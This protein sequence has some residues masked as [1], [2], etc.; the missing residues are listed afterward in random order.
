MSQDSI[1]PV[2]NA[3]T[4]T[5]SFDATQPVRLSVINNDGE[6]NVKGTDGDTITVTATLV[7]AHGG[8]TGREPK[9]DF[10]VEEHDNAISIRPNWQVGNTVSDI[11]Q[12]VKTQLKE[13]FRSEDWDF[14]KMRFAGDATYD[15]EV[16][17]PRHLP[18]GSSVALKTTSGDVHV[19]GLRTTLSV[20]TASG[21]SRVER[22]EGKTSSHSASGD[23]TLRQ[24]SGSVEANTASGDVS[25]EDGDAWTALRS[26]SG[27]ISVRNVTLKNARITTVSGNV[28]VD[29]T[30]NN[31]A[32][33]SFDSVSGDMR[34]TT[35]V[36]SSGAT[37]TYRSMSGDAHMEGDWTKGGGKRSWTI[38]GAE[39]GPKIS[40]KTVSG[41]LRAHGTIS[42]DLETRTETMPKEVEE[43][44]EHAAESTGAETAGAA[45]ADERPITVDADW[46]KAKSWLKDITSR[47][48][49][50]VNDLDNAGEERMRQR[51]QAHE[52]QTQPIVVEPLDSQAASAPTEP[53]APK[54]PEDPTTPIP[55]VPPVP[56][57]APEKPD[58]AQETTAERRLRLLQA[59]QRGEL[60]V[61]EALAQLDGPNEA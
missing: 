49:K 44:P 53:I 35:L 50:F 60:T 1:V 58:D 28:T 22:V 59:V 37:L 56:P 19:D 29:A 13:G 31:A 55:P 32:D 12:K 2:E 34:L 48:S 23:I 5:F 21:D 24:I 16:G 4:F 40:V 42:G 38:R 41:D 27:D 3:P 15:L 33:Y 54:R 18:K 52:S 8:E 47:V 6:I 30:V 17:V 10:V 36:P 43:Q 14:K 9:D 20:A 45:T 46:D 57:V 39:G 7:R 25:Y 51:Q 11:A 26:V 61:D